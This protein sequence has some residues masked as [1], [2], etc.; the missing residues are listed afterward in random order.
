[1]CVVLTR[2]EVIS[3]YT[4]ELF[5]IKQIYDEVVFYEVRDCKP[6]CIGGIIN[7]IRL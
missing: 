4:I 3:N 6:I 1:M 7:E 2:D 5:T